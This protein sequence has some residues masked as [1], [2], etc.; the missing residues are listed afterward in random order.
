MYQMEIERVRFLVCNYAKI[1]I[2]KIQRQKEYL[3]SHPD[4]LERL[5][6]A[7]RQFLSKLQNLDHQ[8]TQETVTKRLLPEEHE[9][10]FDKNASQWK[11]AAP[12][13]D[14][15]HNEISFTTSFFLILYES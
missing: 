4:S 1:R 7:E 14:V 3:L 8:Y 13:F 6:D 10:I 5:S 15:S 12:K 11:F 2:M 9:E